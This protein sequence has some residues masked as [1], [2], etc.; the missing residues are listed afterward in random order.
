MQGRS[1]RHEDLPPEREGKR[2]R[3]PD[4]QRHE[5]S[6]EY[7][8]RGPWSLITR[9]GRSMRGSSSASSRDNSRESWLVSGGKRHHLAR[10]PRCF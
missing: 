1:G 4:G 7:L 3:R 2:A 5:C 9:D 6:K 10:H 8:S